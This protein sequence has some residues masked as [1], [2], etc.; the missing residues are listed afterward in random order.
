MLVSYFGER[1][2][3]K[4]FETQKHKKIC[5]YD[6]INSFTIGIGNFFL[7]LESFVWE[8]LNLKE[9]GMK[10]FVLKTEEFIRLFFEIIK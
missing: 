4:F 5:F 8:K 1:K 7:K 2:K 9:K 6:Q 3:G 10:I